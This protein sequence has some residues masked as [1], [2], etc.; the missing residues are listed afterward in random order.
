MRFNVGLLTPITVCNMPEDNGIKVIRIVLFTAI[1]LIIVEM[2]PWSLSLVA[3][4][5][6]YAILGTM[7]FFLTFF[8]MYISVV[9]FLRWEG[10]PSMANLGFDLGD[11]KLVPQTII[12][13]IAGFGAAILVFIIALVFGGAIRPANEITG[14]LLLGEVIITIPTALFEELSHRGYLLQRMDELWGRGK[15]ILVSSLVFS[16]LHFSWWTPL[17]V[18]P[19]HLVLLFTFDIMLGG[20]VLSLGYY[21]SGRKLWVPIAFHFAWNMVAYILFPYYPVDYVWRPEIFQI[22]WGITTIVGFLFGLSILWL[23]LQKKSNQK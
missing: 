6:L 2:T 22:E 16:L 19:L 4:T 10:H 1:M 18:V 3:G 13:L 20:I 21:L 23:A 8:L 7:L 17:G 9:G 12:G 11:R 14:D 5:E 15:A